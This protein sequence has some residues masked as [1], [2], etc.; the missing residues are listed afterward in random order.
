M[1]D[2]PAGDGYVTVAVGC[3]YADVAPLSSTFVADAAGDQLFVRKRLSG[4]AGLP[5]DVQQLV[6]TLRR[7]SRSAGSMVSFHAAFWVIHASA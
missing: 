5:A 7:A 2:R 1:H 6:S 3:D 4:W